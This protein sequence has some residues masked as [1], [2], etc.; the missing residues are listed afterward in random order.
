MVEVMNIC[1]VGPN[2]GLSRDCDPGDHQFDVVLIPEHKRE[3]LLEYIT[4]R[5]QGG[6]EPAAFPAIKGRNIRL[7]TEERNMHIDDKLVKNIKGTL[8]GIELDEH[9]LRFLV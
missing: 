9:R 1:S 4:H 2:L 7:K 6:E 8:F 3:R 5:L